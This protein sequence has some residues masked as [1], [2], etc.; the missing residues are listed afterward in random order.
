MDPEEGRDQFQGQQPPS[1][2]PAGSE[3]TPPPPPP[4]PA[5]ARAQAK[6]EK[7]YNKALRPWYKKKRF[8]IPLAAIVAMGAAAVA[9]GPGEEPDLPVAAE[10]GEE[11]GQPVAA[12]PGEAP[13]YPDRPDRQPED[14]EARLGEPVSVGG[15]TATVTRAEVTHDELFGEQLTVFVELENTTARVRRF[16]DFND[17]RIQDMDGRVLDPAFVNF[18]DDDLGSGDLVAGG[19]ASGTVAFEV[20]AGAYFVIYKPDPFDA[21]RGIWR[22]EV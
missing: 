21:A 16:D 3:A 7:A 19:R 17:W 11:P 10:P 2:G 6:A 14:Q 8:L 1:P 9:A 13:L 4:S 20:P 5:G 15:L 22:I 12:E 18:R